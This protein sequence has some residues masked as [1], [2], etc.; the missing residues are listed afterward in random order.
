MALLSYALT[1][2]A[3]QKQ[4]M[5]ISGDSYDTVLERLVN[6]GTDFIE[7]YCD[8]RFDQT[9]YTN[10]VYDGTGSSFLFLRN[11]PI[12]TTASFTLQNRDSFDNTDSWTT[13]DSQDYFIQYDEGYLERVTGGLDVD[14]LQPIFKELPRHYRV[15]YTAG[16]NYDNTATFLSDVGAG[17]LEL[18]CWILI[19][20]LFNER[21]GNANVTSEHIGDYSVSFS[22]IVMIN[23]KL[24][25]LLTSFKRK[26]SF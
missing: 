16:Y 23:D 5:G 1:T 18:A 22:R 11:F 20:Q 13:I 7:T 15:S 21:K 14:L 10:E 25:E 17:D 24:R 8:R 2:V 26:H 6:S 3:R 19:A 12:S 4:F 9:A